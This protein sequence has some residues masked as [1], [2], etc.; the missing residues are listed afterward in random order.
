[1][2]INRNWLGRVFREEA[3]DDG[4]ADGGAGGDQEQSSNG[5][6]QTPPVEGQQQEHERPE[7]LLDKYATDGKT[8]D[9]ATAEQ[10]KAYK[11][12]SGKFGAFTGAPEEYAEVA[13]SYELKEMGIEISADDP[14]LEAAKEFAKESNMS[15]E[16]FN[17]MVNLYAMQQVA[18]QK[19]QAEYKEQQLKALGPNANSRIENI[20]QW[21]NKNLDPET[22]QG[23]EQIATSAESVKAIERLI[24]MTRSAPMDADGSNNNAGATAEDV[25]SMQF[26]KDEHG[27]RR[28]ATDPEFKARYI[29]LRNEVYGTEDHKQIIG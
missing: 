9:E 22:I 14:M 17:G 10:A 26:E 5:D 16:G 27:N 20:Q 13:L 8:V 6:Q 23:L 12:L 1:M 25:R 15:Q 2:L 4:A 7:W 21:A 19:A 11:E 29:K 18:E 28:I 3:A 24:S